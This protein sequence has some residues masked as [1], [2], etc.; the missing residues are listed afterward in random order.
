MADPPEAL[1]TMGPGRTPAVESLQSS[2]SDSISGVPNADSTSAGPITSAFARIEEAVGGIRERIGDIA[3]GAAE[4]IQ[5]DSPQATEEAPRGVP[6]QEDAARNQEMA[7]AGEV[8]VKAF[9]DIFG[10]DAMMIGHLLFK[11]PPVAIRIRK[12]NITYRWKSLRTKES[13]AIK[14]GSGECYIE[15]DL[16]FVGLGQIRNSLSELIALW[17]KSPFSFI[18][19]AHI[20]RMVYPDNPYDAM[21]VCLETLVMDTVAGTPGTV[22]ATAIMRWFNYKPYSSNF[23]FRRTWTPAAEDAPHPQRQDTEGP[24]TGGRNEENQTQ[25]GQAASPPHQ[26]ADSG[27]TIFDLSSLE[28]PAFMDALRLDLPPEARLTGAMQSENPGDPSIAPTFPVVYPFNSEPFLDYIRSGNDQPV[29]I[30]SWGDAL[31][32]AWSSFVRTKPP[33][34]FD[35][36][37]ETQP[38]VPV[39]VARP[40]ERTSERRPVP[41]SPAAP[42]TSPSAPSPPPAAPSDSPHERD[43]VLWMGDSIAVGFTGVVE[44]EG[45]GQTA[46]LKSWR[47]RYFRP[48][49]GY[50]YFVL[51]R[52]GITTSN[53]LRA[54]NT[55]K[56]DS[57]LKHEG[58]PNG[59]RLAGVIWHC[60]VND[61]TAVDR[62]ISNIQAVTD[63]VIGMG[64]IMVLLP[65][66][67]V[68]DDPPRENQ[69]SNAQQALV[70]STSLRIKEIADNNQQCMF[71]NHH[72]AVV[73]ESKRNSYLA[74][75]HSSFQ[76]ITGAG[77]I[78]IH[79]RA[80]A[81]N[82]MGNLINNSIPW[83]SMSG[84]PR[85]RAPTGDVWTVCN[86]EDGDTIWVWGTNP[87]NTSQ[88]VIRCV[89][90]AYIDTPETYSEY[91]LAAQY[92][93]GGVTPLPE[94]QDSY[95]PAS[96]KYGL[97]AKNALSGQLRRDSQVRIEFKGT[98]RYGRY[99]GVVFKGTRNIN[100]W[101]LERGYAFPMFSTNTEEM[102]P[103]LFAFRRASGQSDT[104]RSPRGVWAQREVTLTGVPSGFPE[105]IQRNLRTLM[106]PADWRTQYVAGPTGGFGG[107]V[108]SRCTTGTYQPSD[109]GDGG[110]PDDS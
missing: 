7:R 44:T 58:R 10:E 80:T 28:D 34:T 104:S 93:A 107:D 69:L 41:V 15:A 5:G 39:T 98:G 94:G 81:Y 19:N 6:H 14:S 101:M 9:T 82:L 64:A 13:I 91:L 87:D 51:A 90:L 109:A 2:G 11:I 21:A 38:E 18:E 74:P 68:G 22:Y 71:V 17:K 75:Y 16:A 95:R 60:A 25:E 83:G 86:V 36:P 46:Q 55:A 89:R 59:S 24:T 77:T 61:G 108:P 27:L 52:S 3:E 65:Y 106:N 67:P 100:Q 88:R 35:D 97:I 78:N 105:S 96:A 54:W 4:L 47:T 23:Y 92:N 76:A 56:S 29:S 49:S 20:R 102:R 85:F 1:P 50:T 79:P 72:V 70:H 73:E 26:T 66:P 103:Y 45:V 63:E 42:D 8:R 110:T 40:R 43:I 12:G 84:E 31:T 32:M 37:V 30:N 48:P 57:R 53:L 99:I 62:V 33:V